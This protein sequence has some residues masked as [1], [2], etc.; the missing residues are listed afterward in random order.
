MPKYFLIAVFVFG[1][2][3]FGACAQEAPNSPDEALLAQIR[4]MTKANG[5]TLTPEQ[6]K[7]WLQK[8]KAL[9]GQILGAIM[10][11]ALL[12][13]NLGNSSAGN[14]SSVGH[15]SPRSNMTEDALAEHIR[16][17]PP[18]SETLRVYERPDGFEVNGQAY[19]DPEGKIRNFGVDPLS[20]LITYLAEVSPGTFVV[21]SGRAGSAEPAFTIAHATQ[22]GSQWQVETVTGKRIVGDSLTM[23]RGAG[24]MVGRETA[25]FVYRPGQGVQN[26]AI[27]G[28]YVVARFQR[29][30]VLGTQ[31]LL[32]ERAENA[33]DHNG[34]N[35]LRS[36]GAAF[37]LGA[38]EDYAL[39]NLTNGTLTKI[40]ISLGGKQ[41][42]TLTNCRARNRFINTCK[43][44][45]FHEDLY[46]NNRENISHY[47]WRINWFATPDGPLLI[48]L[49]DSLRNLVVR[50]LK[51]GKRAVVFSRPLGIARFT[52]LQHPGGTVQV[53]AQLGFSTEAI[54]NVATV[55]S[56]AIAGTSVVDSR[57]EPEV[58]AAR[59]Q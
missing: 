46:D 16:R 23:L 2:T 43:D 37:G 32:V 42:A 39:L 36:L 25:A 9:R 52:A 40:N 54:D 30:D 27:P 44:A 47:F 51:T 22:S 13:A 6:E 35:S 19:V 5:I 8:H 33:N 38:T 20:G 26:V 31:H 41:V 15:Q 58:T 17:L 59:V 14:E 53:K 4:T 12:G 55:L 1:L 56:G 34:L 18:S 29:G 48:S 49:E 45:E 21:K 3:S 10:P 24:L 28:G 57:E 50:D 11:M 7:E